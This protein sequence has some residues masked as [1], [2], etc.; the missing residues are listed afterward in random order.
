MEVKMKGEIINAAT[1]SV[2]VEDV[3]ALKFLYKVVKEW[4]DEEKYFDDEGGEKFREK[5][6]LDKTNQMG[7]ELWMWW[8]TIKYPDGVNK[9]T[10]YLRYLLDIDYHIL[11]MT[12]AEVMHKGKKLKLDK[13]EVEATI[14]AN[15]E[16][17]Y[18]GEWKKSGLMK[19]F[20]KIFQKRI[21]R[22]EIEDHRLYLYKEA[23]KL[24]ALIKRFLEAKGLFTPEEAKTYTKRGLI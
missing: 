2:K 9:K 3:F 10:G 19:S 6:Y 24:Q 11:N 1:F 18:R 13:G 20:I 7:K 14:V 4:L 23:Y 15:L 17:D 8:R 12:K 21:Y 5:L 22:K 16:L